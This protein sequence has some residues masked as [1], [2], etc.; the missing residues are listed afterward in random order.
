[1]SSTPLS[2]SLLLATPGL[3]DPNFS[4]AV[5]LVL[6]HSEE[7]ALGVIL[8][9]PSDLAVAEVLPRWAD[10]AT[11]PPVI[12]FGG[13]VQPDTALCLGATDTGWRT[14]DV[15]TDDPGDTAVT[16]IRVFAAYAGWGPRQLEAEIEA[17]GW[18]V[19]TALPGDPFS[20]EPLDL[21]ARVLRRQGG[22]TAFAATAP[23]DP[24]AN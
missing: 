24:S 8:N 1:M 22:R 21:W 16:A 18:Y 9:R 20:G 5:V 11:S 15:E 4:R 3:A 10:L 12:F 23:L 6:A 7:G 19:A 14:V 17:G 13:P 2:G